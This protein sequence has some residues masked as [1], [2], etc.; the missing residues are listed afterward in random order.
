LTA[1][2]AFANVTFSGNAADSG[3]GM[4]NSN[5]SPSVMDVIFDATQPWRYGWRWMYNVA[6]NPSLR[7]VTFN[8]N[9][10]SNKGEGWETTTAP[11]P[12]ERDL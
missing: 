12:H 8:V 2:R 9:L 4:F 11:V 5:S 7:N 3:G 6:G 1:A 10:S